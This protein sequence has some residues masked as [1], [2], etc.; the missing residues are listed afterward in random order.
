MSAQVLGVA[1]AGRISERRL[2][3]VRP[4]RPAEEWDPDRFARAQIRGLVRQIFSANAN[5]PVRQLLL[6]AVDPE[7]DVC[8]LCMRIGESLA[9]E[10]L[11][12]I[13][14]VAASP[15]CPREEESLRESMPGWSERSPNGD[16]H[17]SG[18]RVRSN[19]WVLSSRQDDEDSSSAASVRACL[20]EV[21]QEF[22]YSIVEAPP[23]GGANQAITMAQLADGIIL[24]LSAHRTRRAAA[25]RILQT[26]QESGARLLGTVLADREF[27][28][29][30]GIYRR[31]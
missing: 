23:A 14:V 2:A 4:I 25:R 6:S 15:K 26:L 11:A 13:A 28:V 8:D 18:L 17:Q 29:P 16:L 3:E 1:D 31:L 9:I 19:M 7:T 20:S 21:R 24:V 30:D 27:P 10:T 12:S 5:R 22:E